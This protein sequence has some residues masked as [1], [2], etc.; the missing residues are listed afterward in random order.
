MVSPDIAMRIQLFLD[1]APQVE[2]REVPD[3]YD[4]A[5]HRFDWVLT[6][7]EAG[8]HGLLQEICCQLDISL[9]S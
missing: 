6:L 2:V 8:V 1:Y 5:I 7:I 9:S 3:P 4:G